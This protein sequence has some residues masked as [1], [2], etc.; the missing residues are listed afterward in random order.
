MEGTPKEINTAMESAQR[1]QQ[2]RKVFSRRE[3]DESP[4]KRVPSK[5]ATPAHY[6]PL[7]ENMWRISLF[8]EFGNHLASS[9]GSAR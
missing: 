6:A 1:I 4:Q 7:P 3:T 5:K 9:P 8:G 2:T